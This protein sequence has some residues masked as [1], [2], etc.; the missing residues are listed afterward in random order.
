MDVD[1]SPSCKQ[2][3]PEVW[4][5]VGVSASAREAA[6]NAIAICRQCPTRRQCAQAARDRKIH[7]GVWAGL[8]LNDPDVTGKATRDAL[9][10]IADGIDPGELPRRYATGVVAACL[11]TCGRLTRPHGSEADE[12]PGTVRRQVRGMCSACARNR[13][14]HPPRVEADAERGRRRELVAEMTRRQTPTHVIAQ[15]LG[16]NERTVLRD[17]KAANA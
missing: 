16:V 9:D 17:R 11:G 2:H 7:D 8:W 6:D 3:N 13:I 5:P 1:A 12:Y 15:Q 10:K 4:F 14:P